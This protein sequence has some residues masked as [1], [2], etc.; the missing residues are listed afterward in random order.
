M[1]G[2]VDRHGAAYA[3]VF[4]RPSAG[5]VR[6]R[7][8]RVWDEDGRE[9]IDFLAGIAVN[10]VGHAHPDWVAA[11]ADQAATLGHISN[12]FA[13]RPQVELAE[14]LLGLAGM[15]DGSGVFLANSGAEANEA[16]FKLA[17]RHGAEHGG[18]GEI[19]AFE[20]A[21]HGRTMGS[22][23]L[24]HK[25]AYRAPFEPL[26]GGVRH[27]PY[28]DA[29]LAAREITERTAAVIVEP[30]LGEAGVIVPE[31]GFLDALRA[32]TREVGALLIVDEIQTGI[33]RTG[34][35]L[36]SEGIEP[37][38]VTLAKGLGGGFPIGALLMR[39]ESTTALLAQGQHGSTFGGN[40]LAASAALA[41]LGIME[42]EGLLA[43][44]TARGD[45]VR[46]GLEA[47]PQVTAVRG[48]GLLL[49][50][51]LRGGVSA[52]AVVARALEA[53]VIVNA[54]GPST[55]RL[56]PPLVLT[57]ADAEAGLARL[58]EAL[59]ATDPHGPAGHDPH[60][61]ERS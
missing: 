50:A 56:A 53:G 34:R 58:G 15:P 36:A 5:L 28:G 60:G 14:R 2:L 49:G 24:T 45:F 29:G 20:G 43:A 6:G 22:L 37:D 44:A 13:S 4:G 32:R 25:E 59:A 35:W 17:R 3:D 16:A 31:P 18:R 47:L 21:F 7:G 57:E 33:G 9:L 30:L 61:K 26:P 23:A 52:P 12:L 51:D 39:G 46:A 11:L 38:A 55:L 42:R 19:L 1:S 54:T 48:E 40:P 10:S 27:I 41:T 8:A